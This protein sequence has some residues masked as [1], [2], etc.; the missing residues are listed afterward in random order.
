MLDLGAPVDSLLYAKDARRSLAVLQYLCIVQP[1]QNHSSLK[2][3]LRRGA[4]V[5]KGAGGSWSPFGGCVG[6][7]NMPGAQLLIDFG[8]DWGDCESL[9]WAARS[10]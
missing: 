8:A 7:E 5:N 10:N 9:V 4:D 3:L 6:S 1:H 2:L